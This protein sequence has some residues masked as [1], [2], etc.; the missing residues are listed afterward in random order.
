MEELRKEVTWSELYFEALCINTEKTA[1]GSET[2]K[3]GLYVTISS[4]VFLAIIQ[5]VSD[6][7]SAEI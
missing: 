4:T 2:M 6:G 5:W 1:G 3:K 7:K